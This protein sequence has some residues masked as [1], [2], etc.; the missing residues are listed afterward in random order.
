[1]S[2]S[3]VVSVIIGF[4][5][6]IVAFVLEGGHVSSLFAPTAAIIVFGGTA[7]AVGLSFPAE[8]L[9]RIPKILKVAFS[10]RNSDVGNLIEYFKN[11]AIKTRKEGLL[12]IEEEIS[13]DD[14]IDPFIKKGLQLVVDGVEPQ[15]V[16]SVLEA[17]AYATFE[18][19]KSGIAIFEGAGGFAPTMGIIGTVMGLV[20][21]L[22]NLSDPDNLGPSIAVAFIATLYGVASANL[23]WLP[24]GNK[25]KALNKQE[26]R[27]KELIIEAILSIQEG[28]NPNT[29]VEKLKSFLDKEQHKKI[30]D[31][32]GGAD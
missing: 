12:S 26:N 5:A 32:D 17:E 22:G 14:T 13:N 18:R 16:R 10:K 20:H 31:S 24:I 23:L 27:E 11:I 1:L 21:V 8:D 15:T 9:K 19:H 6:L 3:S 4:A 30:K 28:L 25:L 7:G 2:V 29:L